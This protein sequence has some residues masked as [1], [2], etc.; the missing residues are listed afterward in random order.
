MATKYDIA[1][2]LVRVTTVPEVGHRGPKHVDVRTFFG[3]F[4]FYGVYFF[5]YCL[6]M[7]SIC[8]MSS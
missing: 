4:M 2:I 5:K 3:N 8:R 7:G 6:F 1:I